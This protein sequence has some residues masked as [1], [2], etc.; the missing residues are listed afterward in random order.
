M[1]AQPLSFILID[2]P[3]LNLH[4]RLQGQ[5][6]AAL[7]SYASI[8]ILFST[9]NVGLARTEADR[10]YSFVP[11]PSRVGVTEVKPYE[12]TP[13]LAELVGELSFSGYREIGFDGILLVEGRT[14]A[15]VMREFLKK[16]DVEARLLVAPLGGSD[17][18]GAHSEAELLE[19]TRI[20]NNIWCLIDSEKSAADDVVPADRMKF[21]EDCSAAG[22]E[23]HILDF[24]ATEN[25]FNDRAVKAVLGTNFS[26]L[27]PYDKL[28]E[29]Q[30][31]WGKPENWKIAREMSRDETD[32]TDLGG[33]LSRILAELETT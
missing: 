26:G 15:R 3:E 18:I 5:Y 12:E 2:E 22:I 9:H 20:T 7:S 19:L 10:S 8:G 31:S 32:Q 24:R 6:L 23:C 21:R 4:P 1:T 11:V 13:R 14:D 29:R 33:F 17:M 27:G 30:P 25:Y 16:Y 28:N